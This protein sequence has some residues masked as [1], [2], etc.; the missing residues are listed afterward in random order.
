[1][2][3]LSPALA[4]AL[5]GERP[6]VLG[7]VRLALPGGTVRLLD[8]SGALIVDGEA[9]VGRD[10]SWG[11]LDTIKGLSDS[12]GDNA[13][14]ITVGMIPS[15][16]LALA[17]MLD[18]ALQGSE[19][20]IAIGAADPATGLLIDSYELFAGE[21]DT[22]TPTWGEHDRRVD[23]RCTTIWERLFTVEEGRRLSDAFHQSVWPGE[24]GL[25][26]VTGVENP[27]AWGQQLETS[28]DAIRT[29]NRVPGEASIGWAGYTGRGAGAFV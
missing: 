24:L 17:T 12:S 5:A 2:S 18:P 6:L 14:A 16:D 8:G 22:A 28:A 20:L 10:E 9:F 19:V 26:F 7:A 3:E 15:G 23:I 11:V 21:I 1:M 4:T 29:D 13:P 27:V 25:A